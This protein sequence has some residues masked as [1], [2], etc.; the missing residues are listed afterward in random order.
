TKD[1]RAD[2]TGHKS[3]GVDG[4]GLQ[5]TDQRIG[6]GEV[7]LREDQPR[8]LA[9]EQE[10][11]PLDSR[12]DRAGDDGPTKLRMMLPTRSQIRLSSSRYLPARLRLCSRCVVNSAQC[13]AVRTFR[14]YGPA[15][16]PHGHVRGRL[17]A[18]RQSANGKAG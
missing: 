6:R 16:C 11:V 15:C 5:R 1:S 13:R 18:Y 14:E 9:V 12:A 3:D 17:L 10:I 7:Q 8:H 4:E 2:R